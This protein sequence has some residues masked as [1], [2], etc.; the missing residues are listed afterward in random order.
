MQSKEKKKAPTTDLIH[1]ITKASSI[2]ENKALLVWAKNLKKIRESNLS[3]L[4]KAQ[5]SISLTL[6]SKVIWPIVKKI[7]S[8]LTKALWTD[9]SWKTRFGIGALAITL[10]TIG[11]QGAGIA[12]LGTAVGVPLYLVIGAGGVLLGTLIDELEE[13]IYK[14]RRKSKTKIIDVS[15]IK[16]KPGISSKKKKLSKPKSEAPRKRIAKPKPSKRSSK[17]KTKTK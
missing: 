5:K 11:G 10:L 3:K 6:N 9:R 7:N 1:F 2:E 17:P 4:E 16:Q 8:Q 13:I 12:A 14:D 15:V